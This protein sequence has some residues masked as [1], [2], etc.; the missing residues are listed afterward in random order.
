[1]HRVFDSHL[2]EERK[3]REK[4]REKKQKGESERAFQAL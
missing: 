4:E 2:K 3:E 1:M